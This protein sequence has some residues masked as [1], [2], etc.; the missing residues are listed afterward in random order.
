MCNCCLINTGS[1]MSNQNKPTHEPIAIHICLSLSMPCTDPVQLQH[2]RKT[3]SPLLS[4]TMGGVC[5]GQFFC[6]SSRRNLI[7]WSWF[8]GAE[9]LTHS[10][11]CFDVHWP[12]LPPWK[13]GLSSGVYWA[14]GNRLT[15][16]RPS[17]A[18]FKDSGK[19]SQLLE[20]RWCMTTFMWTM[21]YTFQSNS[22]SCCPLHCLT[23]PTTQTV[24]IWLQYHHRSFWYSSS[25]S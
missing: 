1:T 20:H 19:S 25:E 13:C 4:C 14:W 6:Q 23:T 8:L 5:H 11:L 18:Q 10:W 21:R 15:H 22:P 9:S 24:D 16:L 7:L 17:L 2:Q 3:L 12:G